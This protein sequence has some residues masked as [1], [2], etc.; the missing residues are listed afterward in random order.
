[1]GLFDR[2]LEDK[3]ILEYPQLYKLT[4]QK[5]DFNTKVFWRWMIMAVYHSIALFFL[6]YGFMHTD[7]TQQNGTVGDHIYMGT[8][9]FTVILFQD[10]F[11]RFY[12]Y[13]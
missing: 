9:I 12:R 7:I 3:I 13:L 10:S 6:V 1:M 8:H 11:Y 5:L 4:Q 2:T